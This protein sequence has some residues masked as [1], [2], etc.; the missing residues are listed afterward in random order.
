MVCSVRFE[1]LPSEN[2]FRILGPEMAYHAIDPCLV[3]ALP[4][5]RPGMVIDDI[6]TFR[7]RTPFFD[8]CLEDGWSGFF[9]AQSGLTCEDETDLNLIHLDDHTDMMPTLLRRCP[10]G[11][12]D[13]ATGRTFDPDR[14]EDWTHAL[15]SGVISIGNFLTALYYG[16]RRLH[17]RHLNNFSTSQYRTYGVQRSDKTYAV[18]F[19]QKFANIRKMPTPSIGDAGT[20][21]GGSDPFAVLANLP[22]GRTIVHIDL[23]YFINDF[24]G[25][26]DQAYSLDDPGLWV[27]AS[28]KLDAFFAAM[29]NLARPVHN[30]IVGAS[31]GFCSAHHWS[32]LLE[33]LNTRIE[34][35]GD[36]PD[37][38]P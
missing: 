11:L 26:S 10:N 17:V 36:R 18:A 1:L 24:N 27:E 19:D 14:P 3:Q 29:Q 30:W 20:Y 35:L 8:F 25:N 7:E 37:G 5:L 21:K 12:E 2:A 15:E 6:A 34:R 13:P 38:T 9:I 33:E 22:P 16:R 4:V 32:R 23:D 31:P 28:A